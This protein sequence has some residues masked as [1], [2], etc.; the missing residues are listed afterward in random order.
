MGVAD[1]I[2][3]VSGGTVALLLGIYDQLIKQVSTASSAI[4]SLIRGDVEGC[5]QR[6]R[7]VQ[8]SFLA[9]LLLGIA[10]ALLLLASWLRT[11]IHERPVI[12]SSVFF[13]VIAVS[14]FMTRRE[15]R[16]WT[17]LLYLTFGVVAIATFSLL[18]VRSGS[19]NNPT[20]F[21]ALS[22][23]AIAICAMILPGISGSFVLLMLGLYDHVIAALEQRD[24]SVLGMYAIGALIGLALCSR[25][26]HMRLMAYRDLVVSVL[27]GLMVGSLRVLWPWPSDQGGLE[28]TRLE[29]PLVDE[30]LGA[31]IAALL[32]GAAVVVLVVVVA[33]KENF[34]NDDALEMPK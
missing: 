23:G 2:P 11:Q 12:V 13:G 32:G 20:A 22:A 31:S 29:T 14:A 4:G 30:L 3:G 1:I 8:W 6:L 9:S 24:A 17:P 26:L 25:V 5:K 10:M 34:D 15:I 7:S 18:G 21:V 16:K 27:L 19:L 28:N 33:R